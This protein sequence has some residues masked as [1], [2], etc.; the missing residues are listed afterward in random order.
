MS[1][2]FRWMARMFC[3]PMRNRCFCAGDSDS[4]C[5]SANPYTIP[6]QHSQSLPRRRQPASVQNCASK[7]VESAAGLTDGCL[8]NGGPE[9][10]VPAGRA[11]H[12]PTTP[13]AYRSSAVLAESTKSASRG[14]A[15]KR[16]YRPIARNRR[17]FSWFAI[18]VAPTRSSRHPSVFSHARCRSRKPEQLSHRASVLSRDEGNVLSSIPRRGVERTAVRR[19]LPALGRHAPFHMAVN[20]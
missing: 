17:A 11:P 19:V 5:G 4:N 15:A 7:R 9:L 16:R 12:R 8:E 1:R 2:S 6:S 3:G 18:R 14:G 13:T 20:C 10:G